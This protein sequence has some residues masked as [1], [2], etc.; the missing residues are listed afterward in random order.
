L[1]TAFWPAG[2]G[3]IRAAATRVLAAWPR[4]HTDAAGLEPDDVTNGCCKDPFPR[5]RVEALRAI[6]GVPSVALGRM[7]LE[8]IE[9]KTDS[10]LDYALWLTI[11]DLAQPVA[12]GCSLRR[13]E[14]R[15]ARKSTRLCPQ[16]D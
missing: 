8:Y 5:V 9:S 7:G 10:F 16:G 11:N 2:D 15:R 4:T 3:R 1:L 6:A 12:G 14:K 13:L